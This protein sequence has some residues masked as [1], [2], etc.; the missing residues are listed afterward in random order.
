MGR[1]LEFLGFGYFRSG[2]FAVALIGPAIWLAVILAARRFARRRMRQGAWNKD[3]PVHPTESP[4]P[5]RFHGLM[6]PGAPR[7]EREDEE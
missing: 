1:L 4:P 2:Y 7:I 6:T 5:E 3:G